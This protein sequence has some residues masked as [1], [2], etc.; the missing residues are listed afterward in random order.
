M[1]IQFIKLSDLHTWNMPT[2]AAGIIDR[3]SAFPLRQLGSFLRRAKLHTIINDNRKY[4]R[5]TIHSNSNGIVL[6]DIESGHNI[7]T[8]RQFIIKSGQF[9]VSRIDAKN[10]AMGL[11]PIELDGSVVTAD[12]LAFEI[13]SSQIHPSYLALITSTDT[14]TKIC[15]EANNNAVN[16]QRIDEKAFL[17]LSI[18]LP[19]IIKQIQLVSDYNELSNKSTQNTTEAIDAAES[20]NSYLLTSL[21]IVKPSA[22]HQIGN[23]HLVNY[24]D[25]DSWDISS[26]VHNRRLE[27]ITP[28]RYLSDFIAYFMHDNHGRPLRMQPTNSMT[29]ELF[30]EGLYFIGMEDIEKR[31]GTLLKLELIGNKIKGQA[32]RVPPGFII[33]GKLRPY[34]NKF[35]RNRDDRNDIVCSPE[36]FVFSVTNRLNAEYLMALFSSELITRQIKGDSVGH[37]LRMSQDEFFK[38]KIPYPDLN[39]QT[40]IANRFENMS[41]HV[42]YLSSSSQYLKASAL[43]GFE[44]A[45]FDIL[46]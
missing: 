31:T 10:G 2:M 8:K 14:F 25:L 23:L 44:K 45:V 17:S 40:E 37:R 35:W 42:N 24:S 43:E 27:S 9:L 5:V 46:S 38:L 32:L 28:E 19:P 1:A 41:R 34:L 26:A 12:F 33:Y 36:F 22:R 16:R 15:N 4:Q 3:K 20:F 7:G 21:G 6:R 39:K 11:V 29:A 18:P 13:D 30:Y